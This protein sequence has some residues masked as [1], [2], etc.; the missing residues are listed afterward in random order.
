MKKLLFLSFIVLFL[1]QFFLINDHK[2]TTIVVE[3]KKYPGTAYNYI[4][5]PE[6]VVY[7]YRLTSF[8]AEDGYGTGACTGSGLCTKDFTTNDK[9]WYTYKGKLV[10]AGAT[11]LCLRLKSGV[12]G[13]WNT[14]REGRIYFDYYDEVLKDGWFYTGDL[15]YIDKK[16]FLFLTGRKKDMI[17][18]KNGKKIFLAFD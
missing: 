1:Y 2:T 5:V 9:G 15:G 17:V 3:S 12:C 10:L 18:L 7:D 13:N 16:G 4:E 11:N 14:P 8:Y 6:P